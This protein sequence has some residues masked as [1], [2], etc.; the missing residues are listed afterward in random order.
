MSYEHTL[1]FSTSELPQ[2]WNEVAKASLFLQSS[3]LNALESST[4]FNISHQ[5]I[6]IFMAKKL[7]AVALIQ[8]IDL[9]QLDTFGV[10]DSGIK[11]LIRNFLFKK[12][13]SKLVLVGNN[14]ITGQHAIAYKP[15]IELSEILTYIKSKVIPIYTENHI[16]IFKDFPESQLPKFDSILFKS[17]LRFTSQPS[18]CLHTKSTWLNEDDYILSLTKKYRDQYKRARKKAEGITKRQLDAVEI[19]ALQDEIHELYTHVAKNASFNTF[20]LTKNHFFELKSKMGEKFRFFAYFDQEELIG[21]NTLFQHEKVLETYFLGYNPKIQKD[22]LLYLNMLY[23]MVGCAIVNG[24]TTI[25]FGRTAMEIKSSVGAIPENMFGL[26][27]HRLPFINN[28][29][30]K[31]FSFLEPEIKWIQ[32]HPFKD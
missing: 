4:P 32:R 15:G 14:L 16:Q 23:D 20:F 27:K 1:Y 9:K 19:N 3:F 21:F 8:Q 6:G 18:M 7:C 28:R 31:I 5:Y 12:F 11:M 26:M 13:A 25:N 24:F 10:R 2:D 30:G 17:F 22:K 29:L